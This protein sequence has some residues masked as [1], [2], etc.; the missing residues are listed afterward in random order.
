MSSNHKNDLLIACLVTLLAVGS[1]IF[2]I[3]IKELWAELRGGGIM[4]SERGSV[5]ETHITA[6]TDGRG[7]ARILIDVSLEAD[8]D[9]ADGDKQEIGSNSDT[10]EA[11]II[12]KATEVGSFVDRN[13]PFVC[14][15]C[16]H[17]HSMSS[18]WWDHDT[19]ILEAIGKATVIPVRIAQR[20]T[21]TAMNQEATT[22]FKRTAAPDNNTKSAYLERNMT[23]EEFFGNYRKHN[24]N[25]DTSAEATNNGVAEH[26]YAS[27]LDVATILPGLL[28]YCV[29]SAPPIRQVLEAV[30]PTPALKYHP[31]T[32]YLGSG[33]R[34]TQTHYDS[35]ENVVCLAS[36]GTKTFHLYDPATSSKF[37]YIDRA[38]HGNG[39]PVPPAYSSSRASASSDKLSFPLFKYALPVIVTLNPSDC[40]YVPVYWYHSVVSS[41]E[42]TVSI[43]YWRSPDL[44]ARYLYPDPRQGSSCRVNNTLIFTR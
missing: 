23:A 14:R 17:P 6:N 31:I 16:M 24:G 40:L 33:A 26:W 22:Q 4:S 10:I 41:E 39:S 11:A 19:N 43:N 34:S 1:G 44:S 12:A 9:T 2:A 3:Q 35:L 15:S 38:R 27:Q 37:L 8:D 25:A 30:G 18:G 13:E 28:Q 29:G 36:G 7:V 42:Q 21:T 20:S 32:I 5:G